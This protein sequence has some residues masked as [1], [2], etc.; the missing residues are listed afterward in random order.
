ME[1]KSEKVGNFSRSFIF[2]FSV[3]SQKYR[4]IIRDLYFVS[5]WF[6]GSQI[7][8]NIPEDGCHFF[9]IFQ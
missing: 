9:Y 2:G 8:L 3:C 7:W 5:I 1:E 4:R 6:I